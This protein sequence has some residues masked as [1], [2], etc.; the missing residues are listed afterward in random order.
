MIKITPESK[1][2]W[3][4]LRIQD[5]TSTEVPALFGLSPY[6]TLFEL[7]HRKK[8]GTSVLIEETDRMKW[9]SR[10]ERTIAE[11]I[12]EDQGWKIEPLK[13]YYRIPEFR[14]G[15]SFD[16]AIGDDGIL[17]IK[18][19]SDMAFKSSWSWGDDDTEAPPHIEM[20]V[21]YQLLI[22]GR[23]YAYIGALVG[24]NSIKLI[25]REPSEQIHRVMKKKVSE[26]WDS[27]EK[28]NAPAPDFKRDAEFIKTL[29][30]HA[31]PNTI[32][33]AT[34]NLEITS[35][36]MTYRDLGQEIK[37]KEAERAAVKSQLLMM[38]GDKEKCRGNGYTISCGMIG[39]THVSFDR[40]GFRDFKVNFKKGK[41]NE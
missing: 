26:F 22:S 33:D 14:M 24:G 38:I 21:Q 12:A 35:L 31:E 13:D 8:E 34:D 9:G 15:S 2:H 4:S 20:Q 5:I 10:L 23:K 32:L 17:E 27:I 40:K 36:A 41:L 25:K 37:E 7:W 6:T 16:Y 29:Y 39:P 1:D 3:L 19:V 30:N 28:N 18:N 11:G